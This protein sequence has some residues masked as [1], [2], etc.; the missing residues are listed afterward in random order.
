M[1]RRC[2]DMGSSQAV[3]HRR[4]RGRLTAALLCALAA[5]GASGWL[6]VGAAQAHAAPQRH[7]HGAIVATIVV[8]HPTGPVRGE[9]PNAVLAHEPFTLAAALSP[10]VREIQASWR[11]QAVTAPRMR[12]PPAVV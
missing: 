9:Q 10:P 7:T 4:T 12:G 8:V 3:G 2:P 11:T 5:L 6:W 1:A